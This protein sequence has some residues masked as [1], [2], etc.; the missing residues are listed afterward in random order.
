MLYSERKRTF[1]VYAHEI[2]A[3]AQAEDEGVYLYASQGSPDM[4]HLALRSPFRTQSGAMFHVDTHLDKG[5]V[6]S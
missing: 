2:S 1:G 4:G 3:L 6:S 5:R